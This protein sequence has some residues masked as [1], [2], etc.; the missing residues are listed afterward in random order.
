ME[1]MS[2]SRTV[3]LLTTRS[4]TPMSVWPWKICRLESYS[5]LF[6]MS[7][8]FRKHPN[9][10]SQVCTCLWIALS[11]LR[12]PSASPWRSRPW[13]PGGKS[14]CPSGPCRRRPVFSFAESAFLS[15]VDEFGKK[16]GETAINCLRKICSISISPACHPFSFCEK[17]KI[18]HVIFA[19]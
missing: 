14:G 15:S 12:L 13:T 10:P 19:F 5:Q 18:G 7:K 2:R 11:R 3:L 16:T 4:P 17:I 8:F 1:V 6:F 9:L